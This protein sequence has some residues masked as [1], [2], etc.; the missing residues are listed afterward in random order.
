MSEPTTSAEHLENLFREG[1]ISRADYE[2]LRQT[3]E[4]KAR[5]EAAA[6][7]EAT[8]PATPRKLCKSWTNRQ[9]GRVC[10]GIA[11]YLGLN[12]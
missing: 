11:D 3:L 1:K 2:M 6:R 4:T 8:A 10:G 5:E 7:Q 9:V 12:A